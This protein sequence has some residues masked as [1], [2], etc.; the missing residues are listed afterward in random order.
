MVL[1]LNRED[2]GLFLYLSIYDDRSIS[3]CRKGML[4]KTEAVIPEPD[5]QRESAFWRGKGHP[6]NFQQCGQR[7]EK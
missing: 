7:K 4:Q 1:C 6:S 3:F 2:L 5:A